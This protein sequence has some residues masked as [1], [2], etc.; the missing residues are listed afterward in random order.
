M[1]K[2][3]GLP[4]AGQP[5]T[6]TGDYSEDEILGKF[7]DHQTLIRMFHFQ[8]K[9]WGRHKASDKYLCGFGANFDRFMEAYQGATS[10]VTTQNISANLTMLD[11][12]TVF[13]HLNEFINWLQSLG[14]G[15]QK[16][17]GLLAIRDEMI[18]DAQQLVY[19]LRDFE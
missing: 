16:N 17:H 15:V 19:L 10:K 7:F 18:A 2:L 9:K 13:N 3:T 11:D 5:I 8:T 4:K 1:E 6:A 12:N 14:T